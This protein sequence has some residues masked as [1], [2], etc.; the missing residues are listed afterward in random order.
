MSRLQVQEAPV[1][2]GPGARRAPPRRA[3]SPSLPAPP[4][5]GGDTASLLPGPP[6]QRSEHCSRRS[7]CGPHCS[8]KGE[9]RPQSSVLTPGS[10]RNFHQRLGSRENCGLGAR[11]IV[12]L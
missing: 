6:L 9:P 10:G 3:L 4:A 1:F 7:P 11:V 2:V 12:A 5:T 8:P